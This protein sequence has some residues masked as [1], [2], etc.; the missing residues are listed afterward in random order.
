MKLYDEEELRKKNEKSKRMKNMI[1]V[2]IIF[3]IVL[4]VLLMGG[5]YYLVY[6]PNKI[7]IIYNGA[8]NEKIENMIKPKTDDNGDTAIYFPI[9]QIASIFGYNSGNGD[10]GRNVEGSDNCYVES[11]NEVTIFTNN[12]NIIYKIDKTVQR[13]NTGT[14]Y[15]YE[16][17]KMQ[18]LILKNEDELYVDLEGL[19]KAFN[20]YISTNS[21]MKKI[22][23]T[24]LETLV[25]DAQNKIT[26]KKLGE[27][28]DKFVNYKAILNNMIVIE[29]SAYD[30]KKGVRNLSN[31]EEILGFQYEEITY[32]PSKDSFLVKKDNK[33]GII[34]SDGIVKIKPQYDNLILIDSENGLYLAEDGPFCGVI[35]ENQNLKIYFEYKKIGVDIS[36]FEENDIK[37]EYV[38]LGKLIP[39]QKMDGK[40]IFYKINSTTNSDGEK[41]IE[42]KELIEGFAGFENIGCVVSNV[43]NRGIINNLMIIK[44]Y[45]LVVVQNNTKYGFMDLNGKP[46]L[47]VVYAN[48]FLETISGVTDYCAID[49]SG[50]TIKIIDELKNKGYE[51][52]E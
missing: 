10:Y 7:T 18:R 42:C 4:I 46:V 35:D 28:D 34:G 38:L 14:N 36:Q 13:N 6:N 31:G 12:S 23:I 50:N 22:N 51:K 41:T 17:I 3:T 16:E 5:I 27:L 33:V 43:N 49:G 21:K 39:A 8:E 45:N 15:K 24:S 9:R 1:L 32:V 52:V 11:E 26:E 30:G 40:W 29:S 19:E 20:L 44:E 2:S 48:A 47:G 25:K 37:N